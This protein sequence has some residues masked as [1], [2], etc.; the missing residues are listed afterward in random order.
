MPVNV[1][2]FGGNRNETIENAAIAVGRGAVRQKVFNYIYKSKARFKPVS[3]IARATRLSNVRVLQEGAKLAAN[4]VV[5]RGKV[6]G[7]TAYRK[8]STLSHFKARILQIARNPKLAKKYPTKQRPHGTG[9]NTTVIR[10]RTSGPGPREITVDDVESFKLVRSVKFNPKLKLSKVP[11]AHIKEGLKGIIG[12]TANFTDWGGE[13]NDL[14]TN[15]LRR[16]A[17]RT[18]AAFALK[19]RAT[20]GTLTPKKMGANGDQIG[21][22]AGSPAD[23]LFVVYHS[24]VDESVHE[25]LRVHALGKSMTGRSV[26][27]GVID[28]NDLNRLYQAYRKQFK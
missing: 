10:V 24:K 6:G 26:Y 14:F 25:Q 7:E 16:N 15:K 22:L 12:E 17:S 20:Q 21:R 13:K 27:Y 19:G 28:G 5:E 3:E 23:V 18:T 1:S 4:H 2:D 8:D 11:E 9:G